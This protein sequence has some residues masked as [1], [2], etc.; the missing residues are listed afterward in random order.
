[1]KKKERRIFVI[2]RMGGRAGDWE[3]VDM[4]K[5]SFK[6]AITYH[7]I[8]VAM[9]FFNKDEVEEKCKEKEKKIYKAYNSFIRSSLWHDRLVHISNSNANTNIQNS[10]SLSPSQLLNIQCQYKPIDICIYISRN[11]TNMK[12]AWNEWKAHQS[13]QHTLLHHSQEK[14]TIEG[15]R[16]NHNWSHTIIQSTLTSTL[17]HFYYWF[18]GHLK[19]VGFFPFP[20]SAELNWAREFCVSFFNFVSWHGM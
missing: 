8:S 5:L 9:L 2:E 19:F 15:K 4:V 3:R 1:M 13:T 10:L 12:C 7:A 18:F 14:T 16:K 6:L 17:I 11:K 20:H